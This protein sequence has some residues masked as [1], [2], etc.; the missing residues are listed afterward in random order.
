MKEARKRSDKTFVQGKAEKLKF[1]DSTFDAVFTVT[2]EL[3]DDYKKAV[4]EIARVTKP[5][6]KILVMTLMQ[7]WSLYWFSK[8][9]EID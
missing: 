4:K 8:L 9:N 2:I 6:G 5:N 7:A 3:L 1:E